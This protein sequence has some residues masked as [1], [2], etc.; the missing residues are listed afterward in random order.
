VRLSLESAV[1]TRFSLSVGVGKINAW[2]VVAKIPL[3]AR[4]VNYEKYTIISFGGLAEKY[5][6]VY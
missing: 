5:C 6:H 4:T 2:A 3:Q 1:Y